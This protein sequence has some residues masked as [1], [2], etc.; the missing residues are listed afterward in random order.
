MNLFSL[1]EVFAFLLLC[2]SF[3]NFVERWS[4]LGLK[5][6]LGFLCGDWV[7]RR[8][9]VARP[10]CYL[11]LTIL[12]SWRNFR[13]PA[14][15]LLL[16]RR[17]C[18]Q[19]FVELGCC[20]AARNFADSFFRGGRPLGQAPVAARAMILGLPELKRARSVAGG[21]SYHFRAIT[22]GRR[23]VGLRVE[24]FH[25]GPWLMVRWCCYQT[26]V[27]LHHTRSVAA[28][29]A[30]PGLHSS[31]A[32]LSLIDSFGVPVPAPLLW[33]REPK[34]RLAPQQT[35]DWNCPW[36][37]SVSSSPHRHLD[38]EHFPELHLMWTRLGW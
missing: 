5:D 4:Q 23:L 22:Q 6:N 27:F 17:C 29:A 36:Y 12:C 21:F 9:C 32:A 35:P 37:D 30:T 33:S 31:L 3:I 13:S 28:A 2:Q 16:Q 7:L 14:S 25:Y 11:A 8:W 20:C 1:C 24:K 15:A 18:R 26:L 38:S 19:R 10:F 34:D